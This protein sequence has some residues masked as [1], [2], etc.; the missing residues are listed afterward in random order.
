MRVDGQL[1]ERAWQ[2]APVTSGF[3]QV[4][5]TQGAAPEFETRVRVLFDDANVYIGIEALD[6]LGA[7]GVRVQDL[8][9]KFSD[10]A[11]DLVGVTLD[12]LGDG[13]SGVAFEVTPY[14]AQRELQSFD[15]GS[16]LNADWETVWRVR[17]ARDDAGWTAEIAIPW[18]SLRYRAGTDPWRVNFYRLARRANERSGWGPW[19]RQ[20]NQHRLEYGGVLEGLEPPPPKPNV[21]LRPYIVAQGEHVGAGGATIGRTTQRVGGELTWAPR[22]NSVVDLTANTD[23]AQADVDRQV[24]NLTRFSVFFPE[25]RQFFLENAGLFDVGLSRQYGQFQ[26]HPFFSR[27][28]GLDAVGQP[29][30]IQGGGRFV[31]RTPNTSFGVMAIRQGASSN[32]QSSS[33]AVSRLSR[34]L[35][36]SG[37]LGIGVNGR[38]DDDATLATG[39]GERRRTMA[40]T[41]DG[42]TRVGP[43]LSV[44]GLW[45]MTSAIAGRRPG[46]AGYVSATHSSS[47]LYAAFTEGYVSKDYDPSVGFVSQHDVVLSHG[48]V[49]Y[50]WRPSWRPSWVRR[51]FPY[52]GSHV[53]HT[54]SN[55]RPLD[56]FSEA[57]IDIALSN[58]GLLYPNIQHYFHRLDAPFSPLRGVTIPP[59]SYSNVRPNLYLRSDYS[60]KLAGTVDLYTGPFYDRRLHEATLQARYAPVPHVATTLGWTIN[61]MYG[62]DSRRTTHLVAPEMRLSL[63][64][65]THITGFYQYN[66]DA[67]RGAL[68]ARLAWEFAP[69]SYVYLV[70]NDTRAAGPTRSPDP[71]LPRRQLVA[72]VTYLKQL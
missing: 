70:Y 25:R 19:P 50:D 22:P 5:P 9:R 52:L 23:F 61:H 60:A 13:R 69:L 48:V 7:R 18:S 36:S 41:I 1:T 59:G 31:Q 46:A 62:G 21:R 42:F 34:N 45:S 35:G 56:S 55:G 24:V 28:I 47:G 72:K 17:T 39:L 37:R 49:G 11:N 6:S 33:F 2:R 8:R 4:E 65:R 32:A 67:S 30:R 44:D 71:T 15:G 68:N 58:G 63:N 27:R 12:A 20:F 40:A 29:L 43:N 10:A 51:F 14:G 57:Y 53:Y 38:F 64:P 26:I 3:R 54:A 66:S 16:A